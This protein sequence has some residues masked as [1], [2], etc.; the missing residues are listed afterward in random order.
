MA[1]KLDELHDRVNATIIRL[2]REF[3]LIGATVERI[4]PYVFELHG[5]VEDA[6]QE[7][8]TSLDNEHT[9]PLGERE[10]T[11]VERI[12]DLALRP[13]SEKQ[14]SPVLRR[15]ECQRV[16]RL[17]SHFTYTIK[18]IEAW[19]RCPYEY[20][21]DERYAAKYDKALGEFT[22][23]IVSATAPGTCKECKYASITMDGN[24]CKHCE[25]M[26]THVDHEY[27]PEPYFNA[28]FFCGHFERKEDD[29][30]TIQE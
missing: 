28:D 27:D 9:V 26:A 18:D 30:A 12:L 4:L 2:E 3:G 21:T 5:I 24:Y 25:I 19:A 8:H 29:D 7:R 16:F 22:D 15:G 6:F 13:S 17:L 14:E 20:V 1:D 11:P 10:S 23:A